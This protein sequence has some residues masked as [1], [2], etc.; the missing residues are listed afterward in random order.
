MIYVGTDDPP[1]YTGA[2]LTWLDSPSTTSSVEYKLYFRSKS[3][4][5]ISA[6]VGTGGETRAASITAMEIVA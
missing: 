4:G 6:V 1:V 3:G 5:T 2:S